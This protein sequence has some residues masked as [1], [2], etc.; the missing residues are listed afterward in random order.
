MKPSGNTAPVGSIYRRGPPP[1][2]SQSQSDRHRALVVSNT[3]IRAAFY[4]LSLVLTL[5]QKWKKT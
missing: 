4:S 2:A 5:S 1:Y 3:L